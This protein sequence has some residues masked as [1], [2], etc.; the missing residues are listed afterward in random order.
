MS[1][2]KYFGDQN[3]D[4]HG[5]TL[6]WLPPDEGLPPLRNYPGDA[7][8]QSELDRLEH[9]CDFHCESFDLNDPKQKAAYTDIRDRC[10][11]GMY[12]ILHID[13]S[14]FGEKGVIYLEWQQIYGE[15]ANARV[16]SPRGERP[17]HL[18]QHF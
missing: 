16:P 5:G 17:A 9:V 2:L 11:N 14:Q 4:V 6:G 3:P 1:L 12:G 10:A 15:I 18:L 8:T 7:I 13:R